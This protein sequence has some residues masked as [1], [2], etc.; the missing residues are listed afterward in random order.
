MPGGVLD[1]RYEV[2]MG[3]DS[4]AGSEIFQIVP[5]TNGVTLTVDMAV[6]FCD[7]SRR[8]GSDLAQEPLE[9]VTKSL[10]AKSVGRRDYDSGMLVLSRQIYRINQNAELEDELEHEHL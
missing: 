4:S 1:G 3:D 7:F 9:M 10:L 6:D 8:D 2:D 5:A